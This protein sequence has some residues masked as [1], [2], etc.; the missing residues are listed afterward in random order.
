MVVGSSFG[1]PLSSLT[2]GDGVGRL[3]L[4]VLLIGVLFLVVMTVAGH[5]PAWWTAR[6]QSHLRT[7][8]QPNQALLLFAWVMSGR[9]EV[10]RDRPS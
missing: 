4:D 2:F 9:A 10:G 5:P 6:R 3:V 1:G 8:T 7:G